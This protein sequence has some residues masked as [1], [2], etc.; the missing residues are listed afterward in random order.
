MQLNVPRRRLY[1]ILN[2]FEA[3]QVDQAPSHALIPTLSASWPAIP[4]ALRLL[5]AVMTSA[6]LSG[7]GAHP[8][9]TAAAAAAANA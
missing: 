8:G 5:H 7:P 2:V 1:D 9:S 3:V 4:A 6:L